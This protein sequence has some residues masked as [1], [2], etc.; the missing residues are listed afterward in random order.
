MGVADNGGNPRCLPCALFAAAALVGGCTEDDT[1][2][3]DPDA[4]RVF[5]FGPFTLAP[6]EEVTNLCVSAALDNI[7]PM[8]V[9][10][11][12]LT[13][14]N[15]FHH[16]NWF[17]VPTDR[18]RGPDGVWPCDE[19]AFNEPIASFAGGVLFAQST[20]A[21][22]EIQ[23]FPPGAAIP[24]P[25]SSKVI[26]G[27]HL[28][29]A[30][31]EQITVPLTLTVTPRPRA[32]VTTQLRPLA[33]D[34]TALALPAGRRTAL[35]TTCD[36]E[37][38]H[39]QWFGRAPDFRV[40]YF[41]PHYHELGTSMLLEALDSTGA[42]TTIFDNDARV[43]DALGGPIDPAYALAGAGRLRMTCNFDN[44][45]ATDVGYGVGDQEM[46]VLLAF[47]DSPNQWGCQYSG[48][49]GTPIDDGSV[50]RYAHDG[51]I[52]SIEKLD[53]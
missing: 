35:T 41:L 12:E 37:P 25:P 29:N 50:V 20:Q 40:F 48:A 38:M 6:G 17:H 22:H 47:T 46:C 53:L 1:Q 36:L 30:S 45:R 31:D 15:G 2:D 34:N 44:P 14:Q 5:E 9:G 39:Q 33:I 23:E 16:S 42:A 3:P 18:F 10:S 11:V 43:G 52:F 21:T 32:E 13:T 27:L 24:V 8:F 51:S 19:R 28:L 26:A 49:P 4:P 7:D